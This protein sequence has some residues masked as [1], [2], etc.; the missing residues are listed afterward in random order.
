M[1]LILVGSLPY[2]ASHMLMR[3]GAQH[4]QLHRVQ[5]RA[6]LWLTVA[7]AF[8]SLFP[9]NYIAEDTN[10]RWD[11]GYFKTTEPGTSTSQIIETL[12]EPLTAY[13]FPSNTEVSQEIKGYFDQLNGPQFEKI[14][15]DHALEPEL[16]EEPAGS[17]KWLCRLYQR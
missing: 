16:A 7:L 17:R 9:L 8:A 4:I 14:Y 2:M 13:L 1:L 6:Q 10:I 11:L 3:Q 12:S 15:V 5:H